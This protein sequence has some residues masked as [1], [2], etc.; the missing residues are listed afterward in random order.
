MG[1]VAAGAFTLLIKRAFTS[2]DALAKLS[3][4]LG[5]AVENLQ[6][7]QLAAQL[8]GVKVETLN[9]ALQ[10]MTRRLA[11]AAQN[12]GEAQAALKELQKF[13][14][15]SA[16]E[17][18]GGGV[19]EAFLQ[20]AEA[21]SKVGSAADRLRLAFK[22]FDSE[23]AALVQT[24]ISGRKPFDDIRKQ[25]ESMGLLLSRQQLAKI[26]MA[27]NLWKELR[28][29]LSAVAQIFSSQL[30]P[31][32][33]IVAER[34]QKAGNTGGG[35]ADIIGR[36]FNAVA[37]AVAFVIDAVDS[38]RFGF[39]L[40]KAAVLDFAAGAVAAFANIEQSI[41]DFFAASAESPLGAF[42]QDV[43][44]LGAKALAKLE[45]G[46]R[47]AGA[48]LFG[49]IAKGARDLM[50]NISAAA[51]EANK[52]LDNF[53]GQR[54]GGAGFLRDLEA[55]IFHWDALAEAIAKNRLAAAEFAGEIDNVGKNAQ[56]MRGLTGF[57]PALIG[58]VGAQRISGFG[59]NTV[60]NRILDENQ[61]QTKK[62]NDIERA[63]KG[64][65]GVFN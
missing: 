7:F 27:N 16:G 1:A 60:Q 57:A 33:G 58:G 2:A 61:K 59:A 26:E 48:G 21:I 24:M 32:V 47:A 38:L 28:F 19:G 63:I 35:A 22:L 42:L 54:A 8:G 56:R 52:E 39:L 29:Q 37:K 6:V 62:L 34:L 53:V 5:I 4:R 3:D 30:A 12:T 45:K 14:L 13:G 20:I 31:F 25:L 40:A 36:G 43:F 17:L 44:P 46:G 18:V 41:A 64:Q 50:E 55:F 49:G 15:P 51:R 23:G 10:R 11:E 9:M 65:G